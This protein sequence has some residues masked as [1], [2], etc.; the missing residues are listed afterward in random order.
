MLPPR[1]IGP[2]LA[3]PPVGFVGSVLPAT[4]VTLY[5]ITQPIVSSILAV[6]FIGEPPSPGA[7]VGGPLVV[8]GLVITT[9]AAPEEAARS[10]VSLE[11]PLLPP[12]RQSVKTFLIGDTGIWGPSP[13]TP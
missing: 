6:L 13:L 5:G 4:V 8:L 2:A 9:L 1:L 3:S 12:P 11:Q 10:T 7:M